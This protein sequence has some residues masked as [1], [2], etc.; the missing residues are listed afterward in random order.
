MDL[1]R[2]LIGICTKSIVDEELLEK[3]YQLISPYSNDVDRELN[4]YDKHLLDEIR[5]LL[6]KRFNFDDSE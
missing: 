5:L 4:K 2:E 1:R 3:C 6:N